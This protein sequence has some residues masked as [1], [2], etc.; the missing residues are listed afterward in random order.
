MATRRS[1]PEVAPVEPDPLG[2]RRALADRLADRSPELAAAFTAG[3]ASVEHRIGTDGLRR[4]ARMGERL[5][6]GGWADLVVGIR[7]FE[8]GPALLGMI[9]LDGL[10]ALVEML[11]LLT[12]NT[13]ESA[14]AALREAGTSLGSI[15]R[16]SRRPF[17]DL[18][19]VVAGRSRVEVDRCIEHTPAVL[20]P[21]GEDIHAPLL[22][23]ARRAVRVEGGGT[24]SSFHD[25][26]C[27]LSGL[28]EQLHRSLIDEALA[29]DPVNSGLALEMIRG[30]PQVFDR[31]G[32]GVGVGVGAARRWRRAGWELL[33]DPR[34]PDR[35]RSWFRLEAAH[36]REMLSELAGRVDLADAAP[37]LRLYAHALTGRELVVQPVQELVGRGIGWSATGRATT[38][39]TSVY[40]PESIDTFEDHKANFAAF[41]VHTTLQATRLTH[42]SFEYVCGRDGRYLR[43]ATT[44]TDTA[45]CDRLPPMRV[46][47]ECFEDR[48]LIHWLF[49]LVEGTRIDAVVAREYPGIKPWLLRLREVAADARAP[50]PDFTPRQLFAESLVMASLGFPGRCPVPLPAGALELIDVV[51]RRDATVQDSAAA[52]AAL[53]DLAIQVANTPPGTEA[54][55]GGAGRQ[56][57][58]AGTPFDA[59]SQPDHHGA[60]K[61]ETVQTMDLLDGANPDHPGLTHEELSG[62]MRDNVEL[63][64]AGRPIDEA[65][66]ESL[67]DNMGHEVAERRATEHAPTEAHDADA[68]AGAE[69][70]ADTQAEADV[71]WF[72]YDE[73]DFR[74]QDYLSRHCRV[75]ERPAPEGDLGRYRQ[76]LLEHRLLVARTR[77]H[78]EQLRPEAFRRINRIDDGSD[79]DLDEAISFRIDKLAGSGPLARFY[80]RRDKVVRDVAVALL[81]DQS[82]STRESVGHEAV[83][84]I[85][86]MRDATVL[87]VE[88]L[89]ATGDTYGV[90]GF[91][92][93]G[94]QDVEVHVIKALDET[95]DDPVRRR[96]AGMEPLSATR[97]G[98]AIRHTVATLHTHPA[99]VK[100]LMLIS[101]GR[102]EDED[103]GPER[104][105]VEY[106]LHDTRR[107]LVEA[108]RHSIEP[109]LI[110]VD[111][112]GNDYLSQMCGDLGYVVVADVG[113]L[114]RRLPGLYRHLTAR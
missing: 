97:M 32:V 110:T 54:Q 57:G 72:R 7:F 107:A 59:P 64:M 39:G 9:D 35:A 20:A 77:A 38:D 24:V 82:A 33:D 55:A 47:Y 66:L 92:G 45:V 67:L 1:H 43:A 75:G 80:T 12:E 10:E 62:L 11:G 91:S 3:A 108:R 21:L 53:Y 63:G 16:A 42:G 13:A 48:R 85:D 50:R 58:G 51:R 2:H 61:P 102:P 65:D 60:Y 27:A 98:P 112:A 104:G 46:F 29:L 93:Q 109:F 69:A 99:K 26:A 106:P 76:A 36:A 111:V 81:I 52:A 28:P 105:C 89:E 100:L 70:D 25:A 94:H 44:P 86:V 18:L 6:A 96:V 68:G 15:P 41:K 87:M 22:E 83:R 88:A 73:W 114:P 56:G 8:A 40:L 49:A 34:G 17:L 79:I 37:V 84:V 4:W 78:F 101:D 30:A 14:S 113:S 95:L 74:A 90:Y 5:A 19:T 31:L 23:L 71:S 103:Y